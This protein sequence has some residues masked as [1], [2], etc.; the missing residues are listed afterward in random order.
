M[1]EREMRKMIKGYDYVVGEI[2][3]ADNVADLM[4]ALQSRWE[5]YIAAGRHVCYIN[6]NGN[7][8]IAEK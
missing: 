1:K 5:D 2:L 6:I 7:R 8:Y 3:E 4:E